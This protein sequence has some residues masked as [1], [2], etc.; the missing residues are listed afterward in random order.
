MLSVYRSHLENQDPKRAINLRFHLQ[1]LK[2]AKLVTKLSNVFYSV[3]SSN[4]K[5]INYM[6][7]FLGYFDV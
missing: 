6:H 4:E 3:S 2:L 1:D 7:I 5:G